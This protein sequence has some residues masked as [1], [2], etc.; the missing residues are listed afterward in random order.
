MFQIASDNCNKRGLEI[1]SQPIGNWSQ[2]IKKTQ[3]QI[4]G[5]AKIYLEKS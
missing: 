4:R 1:A 5:V 2:S 3:T